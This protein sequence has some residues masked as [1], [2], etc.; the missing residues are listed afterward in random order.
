ML[1]MGDV[2]SNEKSSKMAVE[3][4]FSRTEELRLPPYIFL[5]T[6]G[7]FAHDA[8]CLSFTVNKIC[9]LTPVDS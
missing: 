2:T 8:L 4:Q 5:E 1:G 6:L 3:K 9:T 7:R